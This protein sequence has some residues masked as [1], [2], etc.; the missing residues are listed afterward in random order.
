MAK[1]ATK[2]YVVWK[3]R[4]PGI[5]T[6]WDECK[7]QVERFPGALYKSFASRALA[8]EAF[9]SGRRYDEATPFTEGQASGPAARQGSRAGEVIRES[10]AVDAACA[11]NPGILEYRGVDLATG[12][13]FFREG[14]FAEG[15]NNL[16][17]FLAIVQALEMLTEQKRDCVIYSD[18]E[19]ALGWV[20]AGRVR[21]TLQRSVANQRLFERIEKA[22]QWLRSNRYPNRLLKWRT[23]VWGENPADFGRK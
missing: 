10:V 17:E 22:E 18:S 20:A 9:R 2:Y 13:E 3:G 12:E 11:G 21:T 7:R 8:E 15:T 4:R 5:Y 23:D 16:G 6:T 14:P 19:I 1:G